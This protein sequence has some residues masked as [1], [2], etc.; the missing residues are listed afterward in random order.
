MRTL[1]DGVEKI[2]RMLLVGKRS[3]SIEMDRSP[4]PALRDD[5]RKD[6]SS[7]MLVIYAR[8]Q[9]A[10]FGCDTRPGFLLQAALAQYA[11]EK[12]LAFDQAR[13]GDASG[14][15]MSDVALE[16]CFPARGEAVVDSDIGSEQGAV[17]AFANILDRAEF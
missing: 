10:E 15:T 7:P 17:G 12:G 11:F 6:C 16:R 2:I 3:L 14:Q 13:P 8:Q 9:N 4:V 5:A 1:D